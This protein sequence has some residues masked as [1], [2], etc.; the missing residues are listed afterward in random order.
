MIKFANDFVFGAASSGP[1]SEGN[2]NKM[3]NYKFNPNKLEIS[4]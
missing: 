3:A 2:F 1:Q 4:Q